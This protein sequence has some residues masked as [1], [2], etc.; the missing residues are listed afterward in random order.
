LRYF[1]ELSYN[2]T[3]FH[4]WQYQPNA[5]SVQE[6]VENSLQILLDEDKL[7]ITGAGRTDTGVHAIQMFAH[8]DYHLEIDIPNFI[9]KLNSFLDKNIVIKSIN[10][11]LND[12]HARFDA[13]S[14]EYKYFITQTKD[15]Y[16]SQTKYFFSKK[17]NMIEMDKAIDILKKTNN[18][19]SFCRSKTDVTNYNCDIYDFNYELKNS[20]LIFTISANRFLRN[21]VRSLIGTILD[22]GLLKISNDDLKIIIDKSNRIYA[23][24][25]VPAHGLF[26]TK[27]EYPK[28]IF[29]NEK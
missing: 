16:N 2:G 15:V 22:I 18:F 27:V 23:G 28:N 21:M 4:G 3:T 26:L 14:R 8:F 17:L 25:S 1:I 13:I 6:T 24:P 12:A 20:E 10:R 5:I 7:K 19:Q 29:K 9:F 11:V